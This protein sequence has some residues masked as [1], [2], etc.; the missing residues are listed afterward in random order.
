MNMLGSKL[1]HVSNCFVL[2]DQTISLK[3]E[4]ESHGF[5]RQRVNNICMSNMAAFLYT[6]I[7]ATFALPTHYFSDSNTTE[8]VCDLPIDGTSNRS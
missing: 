3:Q 5:L 6:T 1:I 7:S 4:K 2:V 8:F